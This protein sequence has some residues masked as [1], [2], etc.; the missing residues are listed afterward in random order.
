MSEQAPTAWQALIDDLHAEFDQGHM[1]VFRIV[2][3]H[4][5]AIEAE[6]RAIDRLQMKALR[7]FLRHQWDCALFSSIGPGCTCGLRDLLAALTAT[8]PQP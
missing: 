7:P 3:A 6:A 8:E 2:E 1:H 5:P 4:R